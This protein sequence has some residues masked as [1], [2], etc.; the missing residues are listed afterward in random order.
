MRQISLVAVLVIGVALLATASFGMATTSRR[1]HFSLDPDSMRPWLCDGEPKCIAS[2]DTLPMREI[3]KLLLRRVTSAAAE[4]AAMA[5]DPF[6]AVPMSNPHKA[7]MFEVAMKVRNSG[8]SLAELRKIFAEHRRQAS[9]E[10]LESSQYPYFGV[11]PKYLGGAI[12]GG[13]PI[14][15]STPCFTNVTAQARW[16]SATQVSVD[17]TLSGQ[18][19]FLCTDSMV[20]GASDDIKFEL[21]DAA[22]TVSVILNVSKAVADPTKNWYL[23]SRGVKVMKFRDSFIGAIGDLIDTA[24][25]LSGFAEKP[26]SQE[27]FNANVHFVQSYV[28]FNPARMGPKAQPRTAGAVVARNLDTTDIHSGDAMLL[29]RPDGVDPMI[30]WAEGATVGHSVVFVRDA[31]RNLFVCEST[32]LDAYWPTDG[33]Q[34][35]PWSEWITLAEAAEMNVVLLP[36]DNKY[37]SFFNEANA[38]AFFNETAGLEYGYLNMIFSWL[39]RREGDVPCLPP[40]FDVCLVPPLVESLAIAIDGIFGDNTQNFFRQALNHRV[41]T[42]GPS[43]MLEVMP[44]L[45]YAQTQKGLNSIADIYIIPEQDSWVYQTTQNGKPVVGRAMVCCV[46][47]CHMW[48]AAG[49]FQE[50]GNDINCGEQTLWDIFSMRIFDGSKMGAGRPTLCQLN[51]PNNNLCQLMGN[52][53]LSLEPDVNTRALY[54][55]MGENCSARAPDYIREP[56]C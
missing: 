40:N 24:V 21:F 48:K 34:C 55:R 38:W 27:A 41:G 17:F 22:K 23:Q 43:S 10:K 4:L 3:G 42:W 50:L 32:T 26:L 31:A 5:E 14:S 33:I 8:G 18:T 29:L 54:P 37:R 28:Q 56:G 2:L 19:S 44:L 15:Y 35:H 51:D 6:P 25:M 46:F 12:P 11:I 1:P 16:A 49:V 7:A 47:V 30:G 53:T 39:D 20:I 52:I 9:G 13:A 45:Q 36:L